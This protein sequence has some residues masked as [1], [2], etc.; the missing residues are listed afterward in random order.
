MTG[1]Q[2]HSSSWSE[3]S[4][5]EVCAHDDG[6]FCDG[7]WEVLVRMRHE[8]VHFEK[9]KFLTNSGRKKECSQSK[10]STCKN[11]ACKIFAPNDSQRLYVVSLIAGDVRKSFLQKA[12]KISSASRSEKAKLFSSDILL[13]PTYLYTQTETQRHTHTRARTHK[14]THTHTHKHTHTC[15]QGGGCRYTDK[16]KKKWKQSYILDGVQEILIAVFPSLVATAQLFPHMLIWTCFVQICS[17]CS[18]YITAFYSFLFFALPD[19]LVSVRAHKSLSRQ[20]ADWISDA[21]E[22]HEKCFSGFNRTPTRTS[23]EKSALEAVLFFFWLWSTS[24]SQK[25]AEV[26]CSLF[27]EAG[28][29]GFK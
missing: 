7:L 14:H 2:W 26:N 17:F 13:S 9:K 3:E 5:P 29:V 1:S 28:W 6:I 27:S 4:W 18:P 19:C 12:Y 23:S 8:D 25:I 22:M 11:R 24:S 10:R 15:T 21:L 20:L 16:H